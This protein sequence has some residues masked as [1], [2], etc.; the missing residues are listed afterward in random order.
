MPTVTLSIPIDLTSLLSS[1]AEHPQKKG[2]LCR[3]IKH[4]T[5]KGVA[6]AMII[7]LLIQDD[8]PFDNES[9]LMQLGFRII[10]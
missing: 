3:A 5:A 8:N 9:N 2:E 10:F 4:Y 1:I 6:G 7:I